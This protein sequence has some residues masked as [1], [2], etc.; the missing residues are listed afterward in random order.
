MLTRSLLTVKDAY[1]KDIFSIVLQVQLFYSP[2]SWLE[3]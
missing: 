1:F 3:F 2:Y